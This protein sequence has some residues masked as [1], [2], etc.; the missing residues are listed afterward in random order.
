[1][2]SL[3]LEAWANMDDMRWAADEVAALKNQI[4]DFW[5]VWGDEAEGWFRAW[6]AAHWELRLV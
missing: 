6:R 5:T 3:L 1:M 4:L 2:L